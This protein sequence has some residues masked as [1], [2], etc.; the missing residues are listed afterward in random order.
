[1]TAVSQWGIEFSFTH[2][3][4]FVLWHI[5]IAVYWSLPARLHLLLVQTHHFSL[6]L[7]H[8]KTFTQWDALTVKRLQEVCVCVCHSVSRSKTGVMNQVWTCSM[9]FVSGSIWMIADREIKKQ[10][11]VR[12][13]A[14]GDRLL[15]WFV[16]ITPQHVI[17]VNFF[18]SCLNFLPLVTTKLTIT[19]KPIKGFNGMALYGTA[20]CTVW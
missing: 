9:L 3:F 20:L 7:L 6:L 2:A 12:W 14:A 11:D 13:R 17:K 15:L 4:L 18:T 10:W 5:G 8:M 19:E 1:M 16:T